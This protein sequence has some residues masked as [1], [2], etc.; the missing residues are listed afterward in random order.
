ME[1]LLH[2]GT[3]VGGRTA[4]EI[5]K[6]VL[7]T[8]DLSETRYRLNQL[9]YDL[10]KF[11]G[12]GLLEHDGSRYASASPPKVWRLL[13]CFSSFTSGFADPLPTVASTINRT[14]STD[15]RAGSR[16]P[17][18]VPTRQYRIACR[19]LTRRLQLLESFCQTTF[20]QESNGIYLRSEWLV[21][22][23]Q[24]ISGHNVY[25]MCLGGALTILELQRRKGKWTPRRTLGGRPGGPNTAPHVQ[26]CGVIGSERP[27]YSMECN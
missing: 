14:S 10:R 24:R 11:K 13:S 26:R 23:R 19:R 5:H 16:P 12:H 4:K 17:T 9:S 2:G 6:A 3:H 20:R 27:R 22:R 8:F 18:T 1:V 21:Q 15:P 25:G 7:T